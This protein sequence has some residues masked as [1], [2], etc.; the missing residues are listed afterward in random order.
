MALRANVK[1]EKII[2]DPG[3]GFGK[4]PE[5]NLVVLRRLKELRSLG[6]PILMGTSRKSVIGLALGSP[7]RIGWRAPRPPWP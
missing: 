5:Q 7:R 4:T 6:R 2:V 3:I 1:R